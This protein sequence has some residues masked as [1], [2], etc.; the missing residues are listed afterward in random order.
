MKTAKVALAI[1][2]FIAGSSV[3]GCSSTN[4]QVEPRRETR[5]L[6]SLSSSRQ[7]LPFLELIALEPSSAVQTIDGIKVT[8]RHVPNSELDRFFQDATIFGKNC[9]VK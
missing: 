6:L 2:L 7:P 9:S 5:S 4:A 8:V 1:G 3:N